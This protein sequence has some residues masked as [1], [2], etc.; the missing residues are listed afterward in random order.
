MAFKTHLRQLADAQ[1]QPSGRWRM[2]IASDLDEVEGPLCKCPG[3][4]ASDVEARACP[5]ARARLKVAPFKGNARLPR[6][7]RAK[8]NPSTPS[9]PSTQETPA[10]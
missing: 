6:A 10:P 8:K 4:H 1:G 3:G 2:T 5:V 9:T 7:R